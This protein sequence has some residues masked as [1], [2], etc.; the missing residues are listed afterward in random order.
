MI[1]SYIKSG[2]I[3]SKIRSEASK[4]IKNGLPVIELVEYVENEIIKS[5]AGIAFPCNVS[6]NEISA[7]YTSPLDD[8]TKLVTGDLVKLDLGAEIDGYIADSAVTVMVT[9]DNLEELFSE[10]EIELRNNLITASADGLEAAISTVKDGVEI[11]KIGHAVEDAIRKHKFNPITN[12]TGHSLEQWNL[13]AGLSIPNYNNN[14]TTKL[15]EGQAIAIEPFATNGVGYVNDVPGTY[16][17]SFMKNKPFRMAQTTK[18]LKYIQK[19]H[20]SL[21]FS[22]R[23]LSKEFNDVRLQMAM[24]QLSEAMAIYPYHP[25]KEKSGGLVS[26]KEHT[27]IVEKDGCTVTTL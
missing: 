17:Y 8:K 18:V 1:E 21:P 9:G 2:K 26:Q 3:V 10:E 5:G 7:H 24:K 12:L 11:G 25:L 16:I 15:K 14:D 27:I 20:P 19:N 13:H 22:G 23:W 6:I 4:L